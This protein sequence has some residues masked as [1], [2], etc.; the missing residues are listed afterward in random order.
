MCTF[1]SN[2][3][4]WQCHTSALAHTSLK[5]YCY[6]LLPC[7]G[8]ILLEN[9]TYGLEP[10]PRSTTN[11]HLLYLL[12]DLQSDHVTCGVVGEAASTQKHEPFEPGQSLTSLL[13]VRMIIMFT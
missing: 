12:K 7:R 10:V 1:V 9:E 3:T 6:A 8:V 2:V 11:E 13:R 4:L 5:V